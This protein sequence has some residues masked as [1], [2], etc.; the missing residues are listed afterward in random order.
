MTLVCLKTFYSV[1]CGAFE[2]LM[3]LP[4][5]IGLSR[6]GEELLSVLSAFMIETS[7]LGLSSRCLSLL[8]NISEVLVEFGAGLVLESP[9][10]IIDDFSKSGECS[11]RLKL[12][13][14]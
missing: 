11:P 8:L 3:A 2:M 5:A 7:I 14:C 12:V 9:P 13:L 1:V 10:L 4:R 6:V